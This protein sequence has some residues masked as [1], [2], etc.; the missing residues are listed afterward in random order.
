M[1]ISVPNRL[2]LSD[3]SAVIASRKKGFSSFPT[4]KA[5][6]L[7]FLGFRCSSSSGFCAVAARLPHS[8]P[9]LPST[10]T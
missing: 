8:Q 1:P 10:T 4:S 9:S 2:R 5:I 7:Q 6:I 3:L